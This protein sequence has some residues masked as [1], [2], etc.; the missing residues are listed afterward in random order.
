MRQ[1]F[2]ARDALDFFADFLEGQRAKLKKLRARLDG[3]HQVFRARRRQ[4]E[5]HALG[6]FFQCFQQRVRGFVGELVR[7]VEDHHFVAARGRRV[8]H[9]LAQFA[10]LIDAA[11]RGCVN[12]QHVERSA[13]GNFAAGIAGAVRLGGRA[14]HAVERLGQDARGGRLA[15]AT[16]AGK[17]IGVGDA[18]GIDGIGESLGDVLL[19]DNL[20]ESLRA[21]FSGDNFIGHLARCGS[22]ATRGTS[23]TPRHTR[24]TRYRCSL[25]GLAGFAGNRCTEPEVPPIGSPRRNFCAQNCSA[26]SSTAVHRTKGGS[27]LRSESLL[28]TRTMFR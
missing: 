1:I 3:F 4:D 24:L 21:V 6:R 26:K 9:H 20:T 7:F 18:V 17:N 22:A 15:H 23:G 12:F 16:H 25:P 28:R 8:A 2:F 13:R 5:H 19:P 27:A 10:D 11:I 14:L